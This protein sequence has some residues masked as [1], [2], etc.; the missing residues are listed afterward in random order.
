MYVCLPACL[1]VSTVVR[2]GD[3]FCVGVTAT[4]TT[5]TCLLPESTGGYYKTIQLQRTSAAALVSDAVSLLSYSEPIIK[6]LVADPAACTMVPETG[7]LVGCVRAGNVRITLVGHNFGRSGAVVYVGGLE[8]SGLLHD[9]TTPHSKVSCTLPP[10][11]ALNRGVNVQQ[12]R[13]GGLRQGRGKAGAPGA[14]ASDVGYV[15][16]LDLF[17]ALRSTC[18][19]V[20]WRVLE[21]VW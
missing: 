10:G 1:P 11:T 9:A 5:I 3:E 17:Y 2:I 18:V 19:G 20:R 7:S 14:Q 21:F 12:V 6:S 16:I 13:K 4:E 8:C 15:E